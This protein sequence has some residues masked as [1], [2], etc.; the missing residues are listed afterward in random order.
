MRTFVLVCLVLASTLSTAW[1]ATYYV[2]PSGTN[3]AGACVPGGQATSQMRNTIA[4]GVGCASPGDT[5]IVKDG[6][7]GST[8]LQCGTNASNGSN[9]API[10]VRA[11]HERRA[12]I[13]GSGADVP[14]IINYCAWWV[15]EGIRVSS[16][17]NP[18]NTSDGSV[19]VMNYVSHSVFRRNLVHHNN[20]Y[21]NGSCFAVD[22]TD[23]LYEE[24]EIY[25]CHRNVFTVGD[26]DY[27]SGPGSSGRLTFRRNYIHGRARADI[28]GGRHSLPPD[29]TDGGFTVYPSR[30]NIF[31]NNIAEDV[32]AGFD[33]QGVWLPVNNRY[34]G[35]VVFNLNHGH[36]GA[37]AV[38][39][40]DCGSDNASGMPTNT[41]HE[42]F[43]M[44]GGSVA[45]V[46]NSTKN[47]QVNHAT[48]LG[49]ESN[50]M[51]ANTGYCLEE[52]PA[53]GCGCG[54][55]TAT[56]YGHNMLVA[57]R[58]AYGFIIQ[59][60][61]DAAFDHIHS[62]NNAFGDSFGGWP[63]T[64]STSFDPV[65]GGCTVYI[66]DTS[67]LRT[68][69]TGG[70][71]LGAHILYRYQDG[72]PTAVPLWET[73]TGQF[74]CGETV[75]DSVLDTTASAESCVNVHQRLHVN[76]PDC[77]FPAGYSSGGI[78]PVVGT[79]YIA[80]GGSST[81]DCDAAQVLTTPR[82]KLATVAPC[83]AAGS[84][85]TWRG[86]TY[87]ESWQTSVLGL[88]PG[89]PGTPTVLT[90]YYTGSAFET[91][92]LRSAGG[93]TIAWFDRG[94][95]DHDYV[96]DHLIFDGQNVSG[97]FPFYIDYG[98]S[99]ITLRN[100]EVKNVSDAA[101]VQ[102][103]ASD[104]ITI[105]DT[106]IHE[107]TGTYP[108][109]ALLTVTNTSLLRLTISNSAWSGIFINN[110][111]AVATAQSTVRNVTGA[112]IVVANGTAGRTANNLLYNNGSGMDVQP[113]EASHEISNNTFWSNAGAPIQ[114]ALGATTTT[115]RNNLF[116]SNGNGNAVA[117]ADPGTVQDHNFFGDPT[118]V[119]PGPPTTFH[120]QG[121]SVVGQGATL[122]SVT[123]DFAGTA[124]TVPYTIGAFEDEEVVVPPPPL[125]RGSPYSTTHFFSVQ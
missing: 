103:V 93:D 27:C 62:Y 110:S 96:L 1:S 124:R 60:Q 35:N 52:C 13:R 86:G 91:V 87:V 50:G 14:L 102:V 36:N 106:A 84:T 68:L 8:F 82:D 19:F 111:T 32:G 70:T 39:R 122:G 119:A 117:N 6:E 71:P 51:S 113:G 89:A 97:V 55:G 11:E 20:R 25:G 100:A 94:S 118:F 107:V 33:L 30:D 77:P 80:P 54:D 116:S 26:T 53:T 45:L 85:I 73:T 95:G 16:A 48:L 34:Y 67:P 57:N 56:V 88:A 40:N 114:I 72:V 74:P 69:G 108:A 78:T 9:G 115:Y 64:N 2:S 37:G 23:S 44:I 101:A 24:N 29:T 3:T 121:G 15:W 65:L 5:V 76:A 61:T 66:P 49:G 79:F 31:E 98:A 42:H 83:A 10:T 41:L 58:G 59:N 99:A 125:L 90:A 109:I 92:T 7:Y 47:S 17:D 105:S 46:F 4:G 28:T 22:A 120:V 38:A 112:G 18:S 21:A 123:V 43:A 104:A 63:V 12:W 75:N 81:V